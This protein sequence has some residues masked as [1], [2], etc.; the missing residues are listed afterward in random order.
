MIPLV[1]PAALKTIPWRA[2]GYAAM[3]AAVAFAGWRVNTWHDSYKALPAVREALKR[4]EGCLPNSKC[5][6]RQKALQAEVA[7][8]TVEVVNGYEK[9]LADLRN[10]PP[11]TRI[12]R[13][14]K[15]PP[16]NL[17]GKPSPTGTNGTSAGTGGVYEVDEFNP[18]P[19]FDLA[20]KADEV[21]ARLR[22]LQGFNKAISSVK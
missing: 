10:R 14:C 7:K 18:Q 5:S 3:V 2:I 9:E 16:D 21:S 20:L 4:E 15:A 12:I 22:A 11:V 8:V 1:L 6:E 19:L 13:V 17:S